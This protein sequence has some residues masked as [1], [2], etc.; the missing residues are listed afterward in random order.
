M[1]DSDFIHRLNLDGSWDTICTKCFAT[2]GI[3]ETVDGLAKWE[4]EHTCD[5]VTL[6]QLSKEDNQT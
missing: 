5:P 6:R 1:L 2:V 4:S 3:A